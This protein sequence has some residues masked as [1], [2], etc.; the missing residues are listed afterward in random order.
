MV[1]SQ[2]SE[3]PHHIL[4]VDDDR[5]VCTILVEALTSLTNVVDTAGN[6]IE[7]LE[8]LQQ[9]T[10]DLMIVDMN[11]PKMGGEELIRT[12]HNKGWD[13]A[14]I[15][16]TGHASFDEGFTLLEKYHIS[17]FLQKPVLPTQLRFTVK[18]VL[19]KQELYRKVKNY[20][21]QLRDSNE[22]LE[23]RVYERTKEL[24]SSLQVQMIL[25]NNLLQ[26]TEKL[27]A[28]KSQIDEDL[29]QARYTQQSLLTK[30][31][32]PLSKIK[33]A[34]KYIPMSEVGGDYYD[35]VNLS[36]DQLG[37]FIADTTG[38]GI[39][40]ALLAAMLSALFKMAASESKSPCD[41]LRIL[42]KALK[43]KI[44][45]DKF[46]S[47]FYCIYDEKHQTL[48]YAS[49]GHPPIYLLRHKT[50]EIIPLKTRGSILGIQLQTHLAEENTTT[51]FLPG[52]KLFL[53]T[54]GIIEATNS[55]LE[56]FGEQR[57][58]HYLWQ[59]IH[60]PIDELL[61]VLYHTI[62]KYSESDEQQ[63]EDDVTLLGMEVKMD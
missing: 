37:I 30:P 62:L 43:G 6:G 19:E 24:E 56:M 52:D 50:Q 60:L 28:A 12:V 25:T 16:F 27:K 44:P 42:D 45:P 8:R 47:A 10:Y 4:V 3:P 31:K 51:S 34:S 61:E 15:V 22:Q 36:K 11:M 9:K 59:Y 33:L 7:A 14:L 29:A 58:K 20:A 26:I 38:H 17:D 55:K 54:D 53:Y 57:L 46:V 1:I 63:L 32:T 35:I 41:T 18:N 5:M 40:A 2:E 39:S 48:S 21:E 23:E 13:I 49:A